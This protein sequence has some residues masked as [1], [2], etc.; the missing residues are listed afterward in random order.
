MQRETQ[1]MKSALIKLLPFN[2]GRAVLLP[3]LVKR[4]ARFDDH[5]AQGACAEERLEGYV[6]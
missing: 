4:A 6:S 1:S 3:L 5:V 2:A